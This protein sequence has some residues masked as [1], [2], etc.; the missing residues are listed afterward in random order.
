M[1]ACHAFTRPLAAAKTAP[2]VI[3]SQTFTRTMRIPRQE[4]L[5]QRTA[6]LDHIVG[7]RNKG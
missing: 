2:P 7:E 6:S 3:G 5:M 1:A 4:T